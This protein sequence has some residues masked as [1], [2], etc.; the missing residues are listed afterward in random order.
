MFVE[1]AY[2]TKG[3]GKWF[4]ATKGYG[5]SWENDSCGMIL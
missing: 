4:D 2:M 5:S 1:T 3:K